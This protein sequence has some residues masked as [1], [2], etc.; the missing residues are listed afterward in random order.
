MTEKNKN[1]HHQAA[2]EGNGEHAV[3]QTGPTE[4]ELERMSLPELRKRLQ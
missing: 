2:A 3:R 1:I 4:A